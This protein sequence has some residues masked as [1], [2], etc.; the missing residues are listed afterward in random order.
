V[1]LQWLRR[2][3]TCDY[4]AR[5]STAGARLQ[6]VGAVRAV[7]RPAEVHGGRTRPALFPPDRRAASRIGTPEGTVSLYKEWQG[8]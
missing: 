2:E 4:G 1:R 6:S 3:V 8:R 5:R 7:H